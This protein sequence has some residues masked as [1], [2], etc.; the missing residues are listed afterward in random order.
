MRNRVLVLLRPTVL[1]MLVTVW[2]PVPVAGQSPPASALVNQR[3]QET[4]EAARAA[5]PHTSEETY[6]YFED[7]AEVAIA[8]AIESVWDPTQPRPSSR[9]TPWGDP[10]LGGYWMSASYTPLERPDE[11]AGKP[12]YTPQEAI[13]AFQRAVVRDASVDP[14][15][16]HYDFAEFGL[17]KWQSPIRPN[18]RTALIVD[19]PDGKK[20]ALTAEGRARLRASAPGHTLESRNLY[21]RCI[22]GD[23]GP[24]RIPFGPADGESQ[25]VQT[26]NY[27]VIVTQVNSEVR[28][29]PL[30]GRPPASDDIRAYLGV[31]RGHWE[32]DTLVVETTHFHEKA[33]S[34]RIQ[35]A[36]PDLRLVE[37][38]TRVEEDLLLYEATL[39]DPT[40]WEAPWTVEVPWQRMDPPGLFEFACHEQN[41][42]LINVLTGARIRAAE[43]EAASAR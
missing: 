21:E 6:A 41:Y 15:T 5:S 36:G 8:R 9:H 7:E 29:V 23:Q 14:A 24:P 34:R 19:P 10:E 12:L 26:P 1:G 39:T 2:A 32:G 20:P 13:D 35:E 17:D 33:R 43:Y 30:D 25:I 37:R 4:V 40:A 42:G 27:V 22:T 38:I 3:S 11:L 16:V 18:L 31:S 28:I